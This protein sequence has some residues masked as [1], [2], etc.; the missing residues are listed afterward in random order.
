MR[1]RIFSGNLFL[2]NCQNLDKERKNAEKLMIQLNRSTVLNFKKKEKIL[3]T[4]FQKKTNVYI[5]VPFHFS[6]GINISFG[7]NCYVNYNCNFIDDGKIIIGNNVL[8]GA[9]V[10][11]ATVGHPINPNFREF[12]YTEPVTIEDNCWIGSGV[13]INSGNT[14]GKNTVIGSGSVVTK[15]IPENSVAYGNPCRVVRE[16]NTNDMKYYHREKIIDINELGEVKKIN[17][18]T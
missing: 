16:I 10:T 5:E 8:I 12:M 9:N 3:N 11:I 13:I 14:I 1:E 2:D 6:Y 7:D 18:S 4:I 17:K 15:S